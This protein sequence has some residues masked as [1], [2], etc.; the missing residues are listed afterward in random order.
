MV[1]RFGIASGYGYATVT[2]LN[3]TIVYS[4]PGEDEGHQINGMVWA[5]TVFNKA[6]YG[7]SGG[8]WFFKNGSTN[9]LC[10]IQSGIAIDY[11]YMYFTP[12]S[13]IAAA[14]FTAKTN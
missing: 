6:Q 2:Q 10:G 1:Y 4:D 13:T 12:Y 7:D 8:P 5:T 3:Y 14:G 11:D 9:L